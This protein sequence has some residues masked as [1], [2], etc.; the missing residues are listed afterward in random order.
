MEIDF[1]ID[2]LYAFNTCTRVARFTTLLSNLQKIK[3]KM[4]HYQSEIFIESKI[5]YSEDR[6]S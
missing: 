3:K 6:V 2:I 5:D 1:K 4:Y